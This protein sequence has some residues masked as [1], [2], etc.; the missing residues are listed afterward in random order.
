MLCIALCSLL[1]A[2]A[3]QQSNRQ[4][5]TSEVLSLSLR[6]EKVTAPARADAIVIDLNGTDA[7]CESAGVSVK[8]GTVL[9][10][11][12]GTYLLHGSLSGGSIL[13]DAPQ[14]NVVLLLSDVQI[15]S[16]KNSAA[17][18]TYKA[19]LA[20]VYLEEESENTLCDAQSY[21]FADTR[22]SATEDEPNACLYSKADLVIAGNKR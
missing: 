11:Q 7:T 20:T 5:Q 16:E 18:Y 17:I 8:N 15:Q 22:S 6:Q 19:A 2:C 1:G 13:V 3:V 12:G 10:S 21:T 9:I 4:E 14:A